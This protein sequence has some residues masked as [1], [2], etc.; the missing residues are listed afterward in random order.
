MRFN[1]Y[2]QFRKMS[3]HRMFNH[4]AYEFGVA[5]SQF[6]EEFVD[7]DEMPDSFYKLAVGCKVPFVFTPW[8]TGSDFE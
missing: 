1:N 4:C 7:D 8:F 6:N 2:W 5:G 3:S